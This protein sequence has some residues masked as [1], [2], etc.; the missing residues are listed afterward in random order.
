MRERIMVQGERNGKV[1]GGYYFIS[2]ARESLPGKCTFEQ[3]KE[4]NK[5][6]K[7]TN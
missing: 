2:L 4:E 6:P 3:R 1:C 5:K 7:W